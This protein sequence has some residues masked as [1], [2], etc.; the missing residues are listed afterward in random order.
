MTQHFLLSAKA[1]T[2]SVRR[3]FEMNDEQA[4]KVFKKYAGVMVRPSRVVPAVS[5]T[6][7]ISSPPAANGVVWTA[8]IHFL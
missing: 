5:S 6:N 7:T 3:V 2:L 4:F 8:T 1:R